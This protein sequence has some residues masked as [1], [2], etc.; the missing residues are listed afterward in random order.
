V[1]VGRERELQDVSELVAG[2]DAGPAALV[3]E[4]EAGIGKTT[5]WEGGLEASGRAGRDA[6]LVRCRRR[7]SGR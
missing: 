1:I 7:S 6:A 4:G 5:I 3:V 2:W